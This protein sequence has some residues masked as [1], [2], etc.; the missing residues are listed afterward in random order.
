MEKKYIDMWGAFFSRPV[1]VD[2]Y[3]WN[4]WAVPY[5][6]ED[7]LPELIKFLNENEITGAPWALAGDG[8]KGSHTTEICCD[9]KKFESNDFKCSCNCDECAELWRWEKTNSGA[10][11]VSVGGG[12]WCWSDNSEEELAQEILEWLERDT[13]TKENFH[14]LLNEE[15]H[16]TG[17]QFTEIEFVLGCS[18]WN[19]WE[20]YDPETFLSCINSS[21]ESAGWVNA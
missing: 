17:K 4:G 18:R 5:F 15:T 14:A 16:R 8:V 7:D 21:V 6:A 19:G 3:R 9:W 10:R 11:V 12:A 13:P 20:L 2:S 1:E